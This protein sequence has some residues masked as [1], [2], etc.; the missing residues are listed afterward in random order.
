MQATRQPH[1][2]RSRPESSSKAD[3]SNRQYKQSI[4]TAC[5]VMAGAASGAS[6]QEQPAALPSL[7][8]DAPVTRPRPAASRPT[9]AQL[10]ARAALRNRARQA[11]TVAP[12]LPAPS[13][14]PILARLADANPYANPAAPYK[15]DRLAS[16]RFSQPI[17]NTPKTVTVLTKELL[18]DKN[19]TSL[20]EV[21]RT[22]AG[23][24]LGTG[25]GGNAFGDRFFI[26]GFDARNDIFVDGVRDPSVSIRENF[27]TEQLEILRGPASSFAGRGTAGGAIN[28]VTKQAGDAD[29]YN[30]EGTLASDNTKRVTIDVNKVISPA[31]SIRLN[32]MF[33]EA[34]VA[35]R[36]Y[37]F[38]DRWGLAGAV[39]YEPS[40]DLKITANYL[41]TDLDQLPDFGVPFNR[42]ALRPFTETGLARNTY[43]GFV[44][45]DFQRTKQDIGTI[46]GQYQFNDYLTVSN[47][48]RLGRSVLDYVGTLP[49]APN[50]TNRN[51]ALWTVSANPQSRYQV[52]DVIAN[53]SD[54]TV[55]FN[56][57][58]V[59]HTVVGGVEISRE[60]VSRDSYTGLVSEQLPGGFSGR[61][62]LTVPL[63]N[64]PNLLAFGNAPTRL[65]QPTIIPVDTN[66]VYLLETA[67][68]NDVVILNGGI[69]YDDYHISSEFGGSKVS[70]N[71]GMVNY[72][73]GI[74]VK[75]L[76]NGSLYAAY[77][78]SSN[79]VGAE[80][81]ASSSLYGGL[82][83][84]AT[85][86]QVF[87]PEENTSIEVG[88]KWEFFNKR[89]LATA[90][91]FETRKENARE[92]IAGNI[93]AGAAYRVRGIDLGLSGQITDDWSISAGVVI[94]D[95][96]VE[97]SALA[98]N[99]GLKLANIADRSFNILSKYRLNETFEIGGQITYASRIHGGTLAANA[100]VLPSHW[101]VDAFTEATLT[102]NVT[103][104]VAVT[105][106]FD[107]LYYD[108]FYQSATPFVFVAPG[109]TVSVVAQA[110]F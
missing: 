6:A 24:T 78:T 108:A 97:K 53:V 100:N 107:E 89:L 91:L 52:T 102:K 76:P 110:K 35:G 13:A 30:G 26:R 95:D 62:A 40:A 11:E 81:D 9:A 10:S 1:S 75:P 48:F 56:T 61:G 44:N 27:F 93:V 14:V 5:I 36:N 21:A 59:S 64:P 87:S 15:A 105:N 104:K 80:L 85:T 63:F 4:T 45:R 17:V 96:K 23:V 51:P 19:A 37:V 22:T 103:V 29:F 73:A 12:S 38:D 92:T 109:R 60:R 98:S 55:K 72:N 82:S 39:K 42:A 58:P 32:G 84:T 18:E 94:L 57:G 8:V 88:T 33:Q 34:N 50:V 31:F 101:R 90:A 70:A 99:V 43:Y 2:L 46:N 41:H 106:L 68:W 20:R 67:N 86:N 66:A 3:F 25:E 65:G 28:I 47:K 74:V 83:P 71:T 54:A 69:R 77:A 49:E 7:T 16:N 79:P